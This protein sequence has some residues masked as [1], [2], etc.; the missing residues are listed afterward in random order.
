[1]IRDKKISC[2]IKMNVPFAAWRTEISS[3]HSLVC[4]L[5]EH[6]NIKLKYVELGT[7]NTWASLDKIQEKIPGLRFSRTSVLLMIF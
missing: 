7:L 1:M 3:A 5:S 4:H 2:E 6:W